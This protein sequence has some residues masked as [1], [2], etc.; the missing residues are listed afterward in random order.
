MAERIPRGFI[1][2]L[3]ARTDIIGLIN[4]RIKL[5]KRGNNYH[6]FCPFHTEKTPSFTVHSEKQFYHC[7]GCGAH[8]NAVDFIINYDR[9]EFLESIEEL[10][11]I[12]GITVPYEKRSTASQ[13]EKHQR[14]NIYT[15]MNQIS[16]FYQHSLN[17]LQENKAY[18]YLEQRG[19]NKV[20]IHQFSIGF[21]PSGWDNLLKHFGKRNE[22]LTTL[23]QTGMLVTNNTKRCYDRFR[24]RIMFPIRDKLGR[25]IAFG[26]RAID[27]KVPKYLNSP[28][29]KIFQKS[30]QLYGLYEVHI[31]Q[32]NPRRILLVEGY[33]DVL[34]MAQFGIDYAVSS[35]GTST[36]TEHIQLLFRKT[37]HIV[38]CYDGDKPGRNAAWRTLIISLPY[39]QDGRQISF[40]F[41]PEGEDPDTLIRVEG[42]IAFEKLID[43]AQTLSKFLFETLILQVDISSHDG[44]AKLSALSLP[45]INKVPGETLRFYLRREL[46]Y[47]L[48]ILD[49]SFLNKLIPRRML[50]RN[51]YNKQQHIKPTTMRILIALLIQYPYLAASVPS[52]NGIKKAKLA[53]LPLFIELVETCLAQPDLHTGQLLEKYRDNKYRKQLE[54]LAIWNDIE[55]EIAET[56]F[57]DALNHLFDSVLEERLEILIARARAEK[58]LS[59]EERQEVRLINE[60]RGKKK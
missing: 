39:L 41:L 47:K 35:L 4:T 17:S 33:M 6:A 31:K 25:I 18:H 9:L 19:L 36:T 32:P 30:R 46:G 52:L 28:E 50:S 1:N 20:I 49:D 2:D 55:K 23:N 43:Q 24:E 42:K 8:G 44:R 22:T 58:G 16:E 45:L 34:A 10:A 26:G 57:L 5:E 56:T 54:K 60:A 11:T 13:V 51:T 3:L 15:L 59:T 48:G 40:M 53:G 37:D 12:H 27:G 29:T 38:C 7:F 14:H 21:A